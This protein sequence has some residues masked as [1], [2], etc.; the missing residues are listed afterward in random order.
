MNI[1]LIFPGKVWG[2]AEQ[3]VLD[4][5]Q[6]LSARGHKVTYLCREAKAVTARLEG[7]IAYTALPFGGIFDKTT[8]R[9]LD[10]IVKSADIVHIHDTCFVA[11]LAKAVERSG[12]KAKV[13]LTRH[14]ARA[15]RIMHW[16]RKS[17]LKLHNI[18]FV[19]NLAK[20]LW[21]GAN[22]WMPDDRCHVIHNSI[23][24]SNCAESKTDLRQMYG[25]ATDT[26]ILMF[27]G[28]VRKSKGC[29][30]IIQA[31]GEISGRNWSMIFVG[32][33]KP[34]DYDTHLIKLAKQLGIEQKIHFFGFSFETRTLIRESDIGIAPS[35]VREA[36]PLSPMEFMQAG[37]CII[38]SD[39]GAQPEYITNGDTGILITPGDADSLANALRQVLENAAI[40][41]KLGTNAA[42]Y[43]NAHMSYTT[44]ID[45]I[46]QAY[47]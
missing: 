20:K 46:I 34:N 45:K 37:K 39:N 33:P 1:V 36:C 2:G 10:E 30:V 28:R 22:P 8:P 19:S 4:L 6:A 14:I 16:Q 43:F 23:P 31:L 32:T 3:Y 25:I 12:S 27:T 18:I 44:F 26:P 41:N 42:A 5:G 17:F 11:P 38:A 21:L 24:E 35:I 40:R 47:N 7:N 29:A 13:I 9:V 15:S